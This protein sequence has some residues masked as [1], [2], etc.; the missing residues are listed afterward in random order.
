[1]SCDRHLRGGSSG[2]II[3]RSVSAPGISSLPLDRTTGTERRRSEPIRRPIPHL[4]WGRDR[5]RLGSNQGWGES[6]A[7]LLLGRES[8][9]VYKPWERD[10]GRTRP[11]NEW[12]KPERLERYYFAVEGL[13]LLFLLGV[14]GI[15]VLVVFG[16]L[17]WWIPAFF[18]TADYRLGDDELEYRRGVFFRQKTT[19]PYD[20][21][22][23]VNAAQGPLQRLVGAG[24][25]GIHTAGYGGQTGAELTIGGVG[26]YEDIKD[27]ILTEVRGR[28]PM[29]TESGGTADPSGDFTDR[30]G[31][32]PDEATGV[33]SDELLVELRRIRE[34]LERG[35]AV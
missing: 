30:T 17:T 1:V 2:S 29:A 20:H 6:S 19:V 33:G 34:L 13:A 8:P 10:D 23:N 32:R 11:E 18:R 5:D 3:T 28:R 24:A 31:R 7:R 14:V 4:G 16:F 15:L 21:I 9:A 27:Q 35:R 26:D 12:F 22:T 25:V